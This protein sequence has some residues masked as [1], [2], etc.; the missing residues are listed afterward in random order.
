MRYFELI[1][2]MY[3]DVETIPISFHDLLLFKDKRH[4]IFQEGETDSDK[5]SRDGWR[6]T[7]T[8]R[9]RL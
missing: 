9:L 5:C 2:G 4:F 7:A 3:V 8:N 6:S 1:H